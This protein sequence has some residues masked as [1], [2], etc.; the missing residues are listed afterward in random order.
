MARVDLQCACG[1]RFFVGDEQLTP[2]RTALCPAC[3][4][5]LEAPAPGHA[6]AA[7]AVAPKAPPPEGRPA[8][9][10][11]V[12]APVNDPKKAAPVVPPASAPAVV[13]A[14]SAGKVAMNL[15]ALVRVRTDVLTL[16]P[17]YMSLVVTPAEK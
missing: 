13:P 3:D 10:I 7:P 15:D 4:A 9:L 5:I 11:P 1:H 2:E 16:H 6:G 12:R 8:P 14:P 17:F